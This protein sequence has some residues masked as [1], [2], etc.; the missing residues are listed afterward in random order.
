MSERKQF[1]KF[2]EHGLK[3][4]GAST[5][6]FADSV[7][8]LLFRASRGIPRRVS[9]LVR[10]ALMM[11]QEQDKSFVDDAVMEAVLDQEDLP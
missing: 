5:K 7:I 2:L 9:Y 3:A 6:L 4:G 10:E 8:E 1:E 11:A